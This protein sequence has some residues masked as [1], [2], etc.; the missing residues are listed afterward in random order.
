MN[1]KELINMPRGMAITADK[2]KATSTLK[3][4]IHMSCVRLWF[5]KRSKI[6]AN[7]VDG[8]GRKKESINP[9]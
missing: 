4:L 2:R 3:T 7:M 9:P 1:L 5:E 6:V 8:D